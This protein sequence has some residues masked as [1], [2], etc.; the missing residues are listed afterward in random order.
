MTKKLEELTPQSRETEWTAAVASRLPGSRTEVHTIYDAR[1][2][3]VTDMYC[4]ECDRAHGTKWAEAIGQSL[5]YANALGRK[6]AVLLLVSDKVKEQ[7]YIGRCAVACAAA[8][9]TF[10]WIDMNDPMKNIEELRHILCGWKSELHALGKKEDVEG[11]LMS[12]TAG[13][14]VGGAILYS[15]ESNA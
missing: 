12:L 8:G 6:P 15:G 1:A 7:V 13:R 10:S 14:V 9:I 3:I 2:D 5:L 11:T 4:I